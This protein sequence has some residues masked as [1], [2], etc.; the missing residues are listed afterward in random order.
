MYVLPQ[1]LDKL[2]YAGTTT[3]LFAIVNAVKLVPYWALGQL[4]PGNLGAAALL[5]PIAVAATFAGVRLV[6]IIPEA[7][8][9]RLIEIALLLVSAKLVVDAL[10]A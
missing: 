9:Y 2:R 6:R 4:S 7:I 10:A 5:L 8:F 3:I 1:R